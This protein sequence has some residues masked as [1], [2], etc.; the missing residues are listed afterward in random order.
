MWAQSLKA[1][2]LVQDCRFRVVEISAV[3]HDFGGIQYGWPEKIYKFFL[4]LPLPIKLWYWFE[5]KVYKLLP[6]G[7]Y[8][9]TQLTLEDGGYCSAMACCDRLKEE[10]PY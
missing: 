10:A 7:R 6:K 2:D 3:K 5:Y 9:D 1:G 8:I 4:W